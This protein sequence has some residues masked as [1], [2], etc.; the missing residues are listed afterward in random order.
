MDG[1]NNHLD[2]DTLRN[3]V[4]NLLNDT[5]SSKEDNKMRKEKKF[6]N[7]RGKYSQKYKDIFMRYPALFNM[8]I[9]RGNEFEKNEFEN[10][11]SKLSA[12]RNKTKTEEEASVE[13]GQ[14]M[15]DKYVKPKLD[16]LENKKD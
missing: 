1:F 5:S 11:L 12:V 13:F 14:E 10:I 8:I 3:L 6:G 4:Y 15:V 16:K 7:I 9:E 2:I